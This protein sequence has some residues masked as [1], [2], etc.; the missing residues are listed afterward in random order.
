MNGTM[1]GRRGGGGRGR[2]SVASRRIVLLLALVL[3]AIFAATSTAQAGTVTVKLHSNDWQVIMWHPVTLPATV[4]VYGP[5]G[6]YRSAS[7]PGSDATLGSKTFTYTFTGAPNGAYR[8]RVAW[9]GRPE[10]N[11]Y[12]TLVWWYPWLTVDF[13]SPR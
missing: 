7:C 6:F 13:T 12:P 3:I 8:I 10:A 9:R 2:R 11:Q 1:A 5:A 4:Y